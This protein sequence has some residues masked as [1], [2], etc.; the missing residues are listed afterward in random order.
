M[1]YVIS[2]AFFVVE[3]VSCLAGK[4]VKIAAAN[5]ALSICFDVS[6][7]VA[8]IQSENMRCQV[9]LKMTLLQ[10]VTKE[11]IITLDVSQGTL[12]SFN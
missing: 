3:L 4:C 6:I 11:I 10:S 12:N 8:I 1:I 5:R 7:V 2:N 9:S